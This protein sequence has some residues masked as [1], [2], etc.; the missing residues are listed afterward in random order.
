M[1]R[2]KD[3][4]YVRAKA[5]GYR[6]RAAYKLVELA[7]HTRLLRPGDCVI[8]VG[9]WPGGWLQVAAQQVGASGKVIGVDVRPIEPLPQRNV[10]TVVGDITEPATQA[11]VMAACS[12]QADVLLSDLSPQL[13]GVRARDEAQAQALANFLLQFAGQILKPGGRLVTKLFMSTAV[14]EYIDRLRAAFRNVRTT[15]LRATRAGSTEMY[16]IATGYRG[17]NPQL[18]AEAAPPPGR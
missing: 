8:D 18:P 11:R 7:A 10:V 12:G 14:P 4:Y 6:S 5:A 3:A 17:A 2:R 16:A 9:A 15:R 1:Y 13:S